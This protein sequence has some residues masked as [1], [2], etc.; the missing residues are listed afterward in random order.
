MREMLQNMPMAAAYVAGPDL[1]YVFANREYR[2]LTGQREL[3]GRRFREALSELAEDRVDRIE[4]VAATGEPFEGRES[5]V[6]LRVRGRGREQ[7]FVDYTYQ[8]VHD[9]AGGVAGVLLYITDITAHVRDRRR[10]EEL[11]ERL[12]VSEERYRT[13]FET[14]PDGVAH[15]NADGSVIGANPA[16]AQIL[17]FEPET[18]TTRSLLAVTRAVREDGSPFQLDDVP[19]RVALR[20]GQVVAGVVIGVRHGQTGETRW[21]RVTAVP[22]ARDEQGRP[23]RAYV[24]MTDITEQRRAEAALQQNNG[25]LGRLREAN[26]L[27]VVVASEERILEANDAYLDIIGRTRSDLEEGLIDW[28]AI[29]PERWIAADDDA[30]EQ[31]RRNGAFQP[32]EKEYVHGDGHLVPILLG[33]AVIDWNPLRWATFVVDLTARQRAEQERAEAARRG[34]EARLRQGERLETV[35]QLTSGIAHDFGN[36]LGV[37]VGYAEMAEDVSRDSDPEL[38]HILTEIRVAAER[39][40]R[41]S[42]DL[43]GFSSRVRSRPQAT[44]LNALIAGIRDLLNVSLSGRA[45]VIFNPWPGDLPAVLGDPG[46]LEQVLLNLALNARDAMPE[47]GTLTISTRPAEFDAERRRRLPG[48]AS[49]RYVELSVAD[50]GIGMTA[51]VRAR[52]FERFFTTKPAGAGTGLG[53]ST[54]HG[55]VA[56]IGGIIDVD[57]EEGRGTIF[58]ILL[59][60]A[61]SDLGKLRRVQAELG[62]P[63]YGNSFVRS[64]CGRRPVGGTWPWVSQSKRLLKTSS[65]RA[66][67]FGY[68]AGL[69]RS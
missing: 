38:R 20:T 45:K 46:Q 5:E 48:A 10:Q 19:V 22:D 41:L 16:A 53:L 51:Q 60:T 69:S 17:G 18:L 62:L 50:T 34:L 7:L 37:I 67:P 24:I 2:R 32:Y 9:D 8:P 13:L 1:V 15:Y 66:R 59:P 42:S 43:L 39:A 29:T 23:R 6:W 33:S 52:I 49:Q 40:T 54:V 36:L 26:V 35:G 27:G 12:A 63:R 30:V 44:E 14:L 47:G 58:R 56:G 4:R 31:L 61:A 68:A 65:A 55:I 25:L 11:A 28:R 21:L 64:S 57:S 3:I